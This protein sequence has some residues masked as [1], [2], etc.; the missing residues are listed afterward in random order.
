MLI[1]VNV[2]ANLN[3]LEE[4]ENGNREIELKAQISGLNNS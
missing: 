1:Y 3:L 2:Y 4:V